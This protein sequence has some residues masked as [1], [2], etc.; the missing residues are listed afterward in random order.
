MTTR[1]CSEAVSMGRRGMINLKRLGRSR[2]CFRMGDFRIGADSEPPDTDS[3]PPVS[4][5][6]LLRMLNHRS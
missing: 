2:R 3:E 6:S 5:S 1:S 4:G